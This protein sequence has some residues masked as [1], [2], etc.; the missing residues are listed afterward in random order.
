MRRVLRILAIGT[1]VVVVLIAALAGGFYLWAVGKRDARLAATYDIP[2]HEFPIPFPLTDVEKEALR[3]E[4]RLT[5]QAGAEPAGSPE[6]GSPE[7]DPLATVDLDQRALDAAI[8]RGK[9]LLEARYACGFCHGSDLGGGLM[10]E[11]ALIGTVKA[12]NLTTGEGSVTATYTAADWDR[13]VRHG[14]NPA[15]HPGFMPSVDYFV[16]SDRELSDIVAYIRSLPPIDRS[17]PP[18]V[19]GPLGTILVATGEFQMSA[20]IHPDHAAPHEVE[21]PPEGPTP[22]FG[23]HLAGICTGCHRADFAGGPIKGGPPDWPPAAN[24]TPHEQGLASW[25]YEDFVKLLRTGL[26]PDG[27]PT[28]VPMAE[29]IPLGNA[30][31]EIELQALWAH[32]Q[33]LPALPDGT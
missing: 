16:M 25:T 27:T 15:G 12:P 32:F 9:H 20:D 7:P 2:H 28:R 19:F 5:S 29:A 33:S 1:L 14:V 4:M 23:R 22:E 17:V 6:P 18:V 13:K 30:M 21:P 26:R 11:D 3:S 31:T 8:V 10:I 24:L